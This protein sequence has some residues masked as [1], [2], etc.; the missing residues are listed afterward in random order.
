[1]ALRIS[2]LWLVLIN[3]QLLTTLVAT[4]RLL[5]SDVSALSVIVTCFPLILGLAF[6]MFPMTL[7]HKLLASRSGQDISSITLQDTSAALAVMIGIYAILSAIPTLAAGLMMHLLA[8]EIGLFGTYL[9]QSSTNFLT[10][11]SRFGIGIGLILLAR[12]LTQ[13]IFPAQAMHSH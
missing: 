6:W 7:A 4:F 11:L 13:R 12:P 8:S 1:M 2:A 10:H 5:Q 3:F 9:K